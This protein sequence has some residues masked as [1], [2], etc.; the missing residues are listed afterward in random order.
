MARKK[1]V[2]YYNNRLQGKHLTEKECDKLEALMKLDKKRGYISDLKH[3][4]YELPP[5]LVTQ[6]K[7]FGSNEGI[8]LEQYLSLI[9]I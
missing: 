7:S 2:V 4:I 8:D 5:S 3:V 1:E 9:H 6:I